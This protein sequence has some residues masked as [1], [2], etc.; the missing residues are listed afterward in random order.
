MVLA[1]H[2]RNG[3]NMNSDEQ[4]QFLKATAI[5]IREEVDRAVAERLAE[6]KFLG[7][8]TEGQVYRQHNTCSYGGSTWICVADL[9]TVRPSTDEPLHWQIVAKRGRD[10]KHAI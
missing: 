3:A 6:F 10:G 1:T 7:S 5:W 4:A 8:W 2:H 9:T